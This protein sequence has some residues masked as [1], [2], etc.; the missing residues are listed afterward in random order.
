MNIEDAISQLDEIMYFGELA[1]KELINLNSHP[2][3]LGHAAMPGDETSLVPSRVLKNNVL[4][5]HDNVYKNM[6]ILH[7]MTYT[8][9]PD[10]NQHES[11]KDFLN[12]KKYS[13]LSLIGGIASIV[14]SILGVELT[15]LDLYNGLPFVV[16]GMVGVAAFGLSLG[17]NYIG[18]N[19]LKMRKSVDNYISDS[20]KYN[21]MIEH[22]DEQTTNLFIGH[23]DC[24][25]ASMDSLFD[26]VLDGK[27][28]SDF[29]NIMKN[30]SVIRDFRRNSMDILDLIKKD[31]YSR[32]N[33][34]QNDFLKNISIN[35]KTIGV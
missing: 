27:N 10:F 35:K 18:Y 31:I 15:Y 7:K 16:S 1:R 24:Y 5:A 9:M 13:K 20:K 29:D 6:S 8:S 28:D 26:R 23:V 21:S 3:F 32:K 25:I 4:T 19:N 33:Y 2:L 11:A 17:Y 22:F 30:Y 12:H 34:S 14:S